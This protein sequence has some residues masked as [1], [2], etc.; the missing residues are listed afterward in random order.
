MSAGL[1]SGFVTLPR[2][3]R[4]DRQFQDGDVSTTLTRSDS[5][6]SFKVDLGPSLMTEVLSLI[7][8]PSCYHMSNHSQAAGEEQEE[9]GEEEE[10]DGSL[11]ETPVQSP[12]VTS[13]NP[14]VGSGSFCRSKNREDSCSSNWTEQEEERRSTWSPQRVELVMEAERFQRAADVLSRHYGG[15]SFT[16]LSNST[17]SPSFS[18]SRKTPCAFSE[19]EEEIKV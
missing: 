12:E 10:H 1:Q 18:C 16:R 8:N 5:L 9:E 13:P 4:L 14:S 19:E 11:A 6:T 15:E 2:L 7:D 3:S 17:P